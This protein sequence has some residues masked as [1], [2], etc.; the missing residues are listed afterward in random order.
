MAGGMTADDDLSGGR[1]LAVIVDSAENLDPITF[2]LR[3]TFVLAQSDE[4][5]RAQRPLLYPVYGSTLTLGKRE[6]DLQPGQLIAVSGKRQRVAIPRAIAVKR[7]CAASMR[8]T[9]RAARRT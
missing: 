9:V 4:L 2:N 8:W 6:P 1:S 5:K 7:S 3:D